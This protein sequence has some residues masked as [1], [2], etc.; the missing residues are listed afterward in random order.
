[1][2]EPMPDGRAGVGW[3]VGSGIGAPCS[4]GR[5]GTHGEPRTR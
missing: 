4:V 1:L 3:T 2:T 5:R